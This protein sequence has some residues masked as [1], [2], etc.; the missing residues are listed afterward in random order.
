MKD[1]YFSLASG[2]QRIAAEKLLW[3]HIL[4]SHNAV[5]KNPL[6]RTHKYTLFVDCGGYTAAL[7]NGDFQT[8]DEDYLNFVDEVGADFYALRD[9]PCELQVLQTWRRTVNDHIEMTI[10][11]HINLL[12]LHEKM[13][14]KSTA[15]PVI[16]GLTLED[17]LHCIDRFREQ[18]LIRDYMAIGTLCRRGGIKEI[19]KIILGIRAEVN[20][21]QLHGFGVK[22]TA[23]KMPGVWDAIHSVDSV[24]WDYAAR[25]KKHRGELSVPEASEIEAR[26]Y[27]LMLENMKR[28][29]EN[30]S[31]LT[32]FQKGVPSA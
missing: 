24:A 14:L 4:V 9:Y 8:S 7:L 18:D 5:R 30:Q 31:K 3:P 26:R 32:M 27:V 17:Y 22:V 28:R 15:I 16:Q 20:R 19:Q 10:S 25:W 1:F 2:S 29:F 23:L 13:G 21:A 11:R 12:E 6:P